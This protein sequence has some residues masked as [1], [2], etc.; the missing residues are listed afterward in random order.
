MSVSAWRA[1]VTLDIAGDASRVTWPAAFPMIR[2][3]W[4]GFTYNKRLWP[5]RQVEQQHEFIQRCPSLES[6]TWSL[7]MCLSLPTH[8][9]GSSIPKTSPCPKIKAFAFHCPAF[10]SENLLEDTL[11]G[12]LKECNNNLTSFESDGVQFE[13]LYGQ[14]LINS[15]ASSLTRLHLNNCGSRT[16]GPL[17]K[18]LSSCPHLVHVYCVE[19]LDARDILGVDH[20]KTTGKPDWDQPLPESIHPLEWACKN[21]QILEIN[22]CGL[23]FKT[24]EW[25]REV[26]RQLA[27]LK[28]LR[29]LDTDD[30]TG[31]VQAKCQ[32]GLDFRLT[33][34]LDILSSLTLLERLS[35]TLCTRT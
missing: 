9:Q 13:W 17:I 11:V 35:F 5:P 30:H 7:S 12:I 28:Q 34:G 1:D 31:A 10:H 2:K 3:L 26:L 33:S 27:K 6:L 15:L 20:D 25:Q 4:I 14:T 24:Q 32:D 16:S 19:P 8:D 22:I 29:V 18:I 21:L 23:Q